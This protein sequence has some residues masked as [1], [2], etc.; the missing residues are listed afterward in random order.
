[1]P[2]KAPGGWRVVYQGM[3][4]VTG[5][6]LASFRLPGAG[7]QGVWVTPPCMLERPALPP[8]GPN[9]RFSAV[10]GV[11]AESAGMRS[12]GKSPAS[13]TFGTRTRLWL[14]S[15][16]IRPAQAGVVASVNPGGRRVVMPNP[17]G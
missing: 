8:D 11:L 2:V 9:K 3:S 15:R 4:P 7:K 1:M 17:S 6:S 12:S 13:E 16:R 10:S 14:V 5:Q